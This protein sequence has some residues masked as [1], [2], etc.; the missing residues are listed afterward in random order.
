MDTICPQGLHRRYGYENAG[1]CDSV[2]G[3][4]GIGK[5]IN[6]SFVVL[7]AIELDNYRHTAL[8]MRGNRY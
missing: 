2:I 5:N 4:S 7:L 3:F 8:Q 6:R 1:W